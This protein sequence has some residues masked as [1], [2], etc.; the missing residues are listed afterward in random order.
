MAP[1]ESDDKEAI[2]NK[3]RGERKSKGERGVQG[4]GGE[5]SEGDVKKQREHLGFEYEA[6]IRF[7]HRS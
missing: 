4:R 6:E 5:R 2:K 7:P 1:P 3:A